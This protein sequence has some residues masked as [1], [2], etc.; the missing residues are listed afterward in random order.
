M[1]TGTHACVR[2]WRACFAARARAHNVIA[3]ATRTHAGGA[4]LRRQHHMESPADDQARDDKNDGRERQ[5]RRVRVMTM[6]RV[7]P[8]AA[9]CVR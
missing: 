9:A 1:E 8:P 5:M 6:A 3:L 2:A 7:P 4:A